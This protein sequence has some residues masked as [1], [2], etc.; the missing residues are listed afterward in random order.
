[1]ATNKAIGLYSETEYG[2]EAALV[3]ARELEALL[4]EQD[5]DPHYL[6]HLPR[7][8]LGAEHEGVIEAWRRVEECRPP[9]EGCECFA[10]WLEIR[11]IEAKVLYHYPAVADRVIQDLK[12]YAGSPLKKP[13]YH[14]FM[15]ECAC[16]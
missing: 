1:M 7:Y 9:R 14:L 5:R 16:R 6:D 13:L 10:D 8:D 4:P 15:G 12:D 2:N 3:T 11:S